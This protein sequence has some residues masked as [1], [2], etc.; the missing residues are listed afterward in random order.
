MK[1]VAMVVSLV[2]AF[3]CGL[4]FWGTFP[5]ETRTYENMQPVDTHAVLCVADSGD[6]ETYYIIM[7]S[8]KGFSDEDV[9][10][11]K[12]SYAQGFCDSIR[13]M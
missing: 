11:L 2:V 5:R 10:D 7:P 9:Y 13:R 6:A 1:N 4:Y 12:E 8:F 3:A